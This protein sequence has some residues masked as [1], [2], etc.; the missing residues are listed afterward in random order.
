MIVDAGAAY[1]TVHDRSGAV[2]THAGQLEFG[3]FNR[4][5]SSALIE[6]NQFGGGNGFADR[7]YFTGEETGGGSMWAVDTASND[8]WGVPA[9][10]RGG[11]ENVTQVDTG[12]DSTVG[13][14]M[15][16]DRGGA[17]LYLY[18]GNKGIGQDGSGSDSFL[19]RNGLA[20]GKLY[21]WK[22]NDATRL[23]PED[24]NG[25]GNSLAGSWVE[26]VNPDPGMAGNAGWDE[27]GYALQEN[28]DAQKVANGSFNLSRPEDVATDPNDGS[29][30]VIASTGRFSLFPSDAWGTMYTIDIDFQNGQPVGAKLEILYDGDDADNRDFGLRN[31]DNLD[32]A[33][34]GTIVVQEDRSV[35][36]FGLASREEA[37]VWQ[38]PSGI[39]GI[40]P[41][42]VAQI[43]RGAV[44]T[45]ELG[46]TDGD[47]D[48]IGD[49]ESSGI[50]DVSVLFGED[51]GSLFLLSVQA[52]S[53]RDGDVTTGGIGGSQ[54]LVQGGQLL[55][56]DL[57]D[58]GP[59]QVSELRP[60][61]LF[62]ADVPFL[63]R[64][65]R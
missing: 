6:A 38:F 26:V 62:V 40:D 36:G 64:R 54:Y 23:S 34:N 50:V 10:G 14:L 7:I 24:F 39:A 11:W 58:A 9:M 48:D 3:S 8:I 51:P 45:T 52:H 44:P 30:A 27:H 41:V 16:D 12:S 17:P 5:C 25:T 60:A 57:S 49:W 18:V 22:A 56:L 32:W 13:I 65:K 4:F 29:R 59:A 42:R 35:G 63:V 43:D 1:D 2:V 61:L 47:P 31:P 37:S 28:L 20:N 15:G 19:A 55:F 21:T 46:Q 33:D 53:I